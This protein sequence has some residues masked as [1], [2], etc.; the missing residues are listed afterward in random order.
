MRVS[1]IDDAL[2]CFVQRLC[3]VQMKI[4]DATLS[5]LTQVQAL[6]G[7]ELEMIKDQRAM[8]ERMKKVNA[9]A[10]AMAEEMKEVNAHFALC[11][12]GMSRARVE[13]RSFMRHQNTHTFFPVWGG[14]E[15]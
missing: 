5:N 6:A 12:A 13:G 14:Q 15:G 4:Y 8:R 7:D 1:A 3:Q 9:H 10:Q 2:T 11:M